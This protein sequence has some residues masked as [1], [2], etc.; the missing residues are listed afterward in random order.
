MGLFVMVSAWNNVYA[1]L[2]NGIGKIKPQ[3]YTAIIAMLLNIPLALLFTKH[4]GLGMSGIVLATC[5]SLLFAAVVLPV[6]VHSMIRNG[7]KGQ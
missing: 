4:F 1:M 2:V 7:I 3:L 5:V 6:Q